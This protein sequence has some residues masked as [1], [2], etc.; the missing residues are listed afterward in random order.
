LSKN[1]I[2]LERYAFAMPPEATQ[3]HES[4]VV[5]NVA[6]RAVPVI[7]GVVPA[8]SIDAARREEV[9]ELGGLVKIIGGEDHGAIPL[10]HVGV[11]TTAVALMIDPEFNHH[12]DSSAHEPHPV[13]GRFRVEAEDYPAHSRFVAPPWW[14]HR[15]G[16]DNPLVVAEGLVFHTMVP[17]ESSPLSGESLASIVTG[18]GGGALVVAVV[19]GVTS[20]WLLVA[21]PAGIV[22][23]KV[24]NGAGDAL[25]DVVKHRLLRWLEPDLLKRVPEE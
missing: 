22:L 14:R 2:D 5:V 12:L 24:A 3:F 20:P 1:R 8:R 21:V 16:P 10:S 9:S 11:L 13:W 17:F 25:H 4:T 6:G 7:F 23:M 18:S 19:G 15:D